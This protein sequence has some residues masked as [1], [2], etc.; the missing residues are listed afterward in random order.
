MLKVSVII[1]NYNHS[2]FLKK[3]ID[4]VLSQSYQ[5]FEVIILD[6]CSSDAS[7]DII[8]S[9]KSH[10]KVKVVEQNIVNS[11][12]TFK[13]W[14]K[15]FSYASGEYIWIAESDDFAHPKFLERMMNLFKS[16]P[17]AV[18]GYSDSIIIDAEDKIIGNSQKWSK[19]Y[20]EF[21]T[22]SGSYSGNTFCEKY[23]IKHCVIPNASAVVIKNEHLL[24]L[25]EVSQQYKVC[26]DW[27][28]WF[29]LLINHQFV[30]LKEDL[31]YF[32][33][34]SGTVRKQ[35]ELLI[36]AESLNLLK[37]FYEDLFSLKR[38]LKWFY[39]SYYDWSFK[40]L[41]WSSVYSFNLSNFAIYFKKSRFI[42]LKYFLY[43]TPRML[44]LKAKINV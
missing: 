37:I 11:G 12:S 29:K 22:K 9:Y 41:Q 14:K 21:L 18:L 40:N 23:M 24:N 42:N 36:K 28:I 34:H 13:Q 32:R 30:Y 16:Y 1:P 38:N 20:S 3:R 26:G 17:E 27:F 5:N 2:A 8:T 39:E 35:K 10:E 15:G 7:W 43:K 19:V 31:N 25:I 44:Y 6:D 33:T 4:S